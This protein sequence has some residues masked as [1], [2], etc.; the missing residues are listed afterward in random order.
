MSATPP[1][2]TNTQLAQAIT[3]YYAFVPG[4]LDAGW[5]RLTSGYQ[6]GHAGG[7]A[8]YRKFWTPIRG[9]STSNVVGQAPDSALATITYHYKNGQ[10]VIERT[11]YR[12]V[13]SGGQWLIS[14]SSL[15]THQ[16]V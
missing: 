15:L 13:R 14:A 3:D 4:N 8:N 5:S 16:T 12:F 6:S 7:F 2:S 11:R 1:G 9:V 10:T